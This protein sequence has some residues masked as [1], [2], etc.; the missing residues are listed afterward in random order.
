[1]SPRKQPRDTPR[2]RPAVRSVALLLLLGALAY[3]TWLLEVFLPTGLSPL[4]SY[5]SELAAEDQ[6][7]GT[8]F[9]TADLLGGLFVLLGAAAALIRLPHRGLTTAGWAGLVLFGAATVA[10]SRLPLSC[11]PAAD[12]ACVARERAGDVP[13]THAAHAF[14]SSIAIVGALVGMVLLTVV[15]RRRADALPLLARTGP[16]VVAVELAATV[17]TLASVAAFDAGHGTWGLGVAQRLQLLSIAV[18]IALLACSLPATA[19]ARGSTGA[20]VR[21]G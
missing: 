15:A 9:R 4:S 11:A 2:A 6:P 18:W 19:A 20:A 3:S 5:V 7:Y 21:R 12:A 14:S 13:W 8:F 1:M 17:W 16:A 10:D